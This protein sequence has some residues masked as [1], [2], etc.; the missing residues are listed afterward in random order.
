MRVRRGRSYRGDEKRQARSLRLK[1]EKDEVK[2]VSR[3]SQE[4]V[5][6]WAV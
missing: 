1:K 5:K 4:D 6:Q 2:H 3:R